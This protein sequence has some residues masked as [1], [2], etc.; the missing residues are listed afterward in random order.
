[1]LASS[2]RVA[3]ASDTVPR[4]GEVRRGN[5]LFNAAARLRLTPLRTHAYYMLEAYNAGAEITG[6]MSVAVQDR[7]GATIMRTP[8]SPVRI[9]EGGGLLKG[10][11]DLEGLPPGS[12]LLSVAVKTPAGAF[13]RSG[14]FVMA[15]L[16]ETLAKD[17]AR[18][19]VEKVG[20]EGY[21]KY[22]DPLKLDSA[23]API[24]YVAESGE[25]RTWDKALS[26]DAKR[27]FLT[28][29]WSKRDPTPG[30]PRNETRE[31]F[32]AGVDFA[33]RAYKE[34]KVPGWKTDRGRI[35]AKYGAP[36]DMLQRYQEQQA[37]PYE[38]WRYTR[39]KARWF[40]FADLSRGL[41][42]YRLVQSNDLSE[43]NRPDWRQILTEDGVR[44]CGR[45]I[46]QDFYG[47]APGP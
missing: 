25:L 29:F 4:V 3:D 28:D 36:D 21:F 40:I 38:C 23:Y 45:F 26:D 27:K 41:G 8:E 35:Y 10:H 37:P 31:Q 16:E 42:Q 5:V 13:E 44:D 33:D 19:A 15:Q 11:V 20:D 24:V 39:G 6:T 46:G 9:G 17:T 34:R 30:T 7:A 47:G 2:M 18:I 12:Y 14:E 22:M 32:Y 43:V 1:M